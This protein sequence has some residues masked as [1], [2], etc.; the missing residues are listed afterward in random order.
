MELLTAAFLLAAVADAELR[1]GYYD[2]LG[3]AG[4]EDR[5]RT[6]VRRS[7]LTDATSS[8]AMLRLAFHDCQVGPVSTSHLN[9]TRPACHSL[10]SYSYRCPSG[11]LLINT[12]EIT[13]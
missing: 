10:S 1:Y 11:L 2:S 8:A 5:V 4:V 6:L 9:V 3:C 12:Q 13:V 7:F